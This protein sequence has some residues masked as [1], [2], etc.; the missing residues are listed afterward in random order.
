[1]VNAEAAFTALTHSF[2]AKLKT[3]KIDWQSSENFKTIIE[4]KANLVVSAKSTS[5]IFKYKGEAYIR[6]ILASFS[7]PKLEL[8]LQRNN[9]EMFRLSPKELID[10]GLS[11][12][13]YLSYG[14]DMPTNYSLRLYFEDKNYLKATESFEILV[15]NPLEADK[16]LLLAICVVAKRI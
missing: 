15:H 7:V 8:I 1:M 4:K 11:A 6:E 16:E 10:A 5:S 2:D 13:T 12:G 9:S 14:M 3:L